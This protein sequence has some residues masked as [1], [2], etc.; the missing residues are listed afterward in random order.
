MSIGDDCMEGNV[1]YVKQGM[2]KVLCRALDENR[3]G[4][5]SG[6]LVGY[7]ERGIKK[8]ENGVLSSFTGVDTHVN[9]C[10]SERIL[11][12]QYMRHFKDQIERYI[13]ALSKMRNQD[14]LVRGDFIFSE[15]TPVYKEDMSSYVEDPCMIPLEPEEWKEKRTAFGTLSYT[16]GERIT[17][18]TEEEAKLLQVM[19]IYSTLYVDPF[20]KAVHTEKQKILV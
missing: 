5:L 13:V 14:V 15:M 3:V 18:M 6:N 4:S 17:P 7:V 8:K 10:R 16:Y 9:L 11:Y 19:H 12:M 2:A 1:Y 20:V